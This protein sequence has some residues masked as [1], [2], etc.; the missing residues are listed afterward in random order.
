MLACHKNI[1]VMTMS[2]NFQLGENSREFKVERQYEDFEWLQHC[3]VT[4]NDVGGLIVSG[5][6][7]QKCVSKRGKYLYKHF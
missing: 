5:T 4:K 1:N 6:P 7:C 3:L 2:I